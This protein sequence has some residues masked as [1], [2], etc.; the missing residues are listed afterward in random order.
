MSVTSDPSGMY[1]RI[2]TRPKGTPDSLSLGQR[3]TTYHRETFR[4]VTR[5]ATAQH[6]RVHTSI[7]IQKV[8]RIHAET[9]YSKLV[10]PMS[11]SIA[12]SPMSSSDILPR[13]SPQIGNKPEV[14]VHSAGTG[15]TAVNVVTLRQAWKREKPT[16]AMCVRNV[17]VQCVCNSH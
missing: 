7:S 17:D 3:Q 5:I 13:D 8:S 4:S 16:S 10:Q 15:E 14:A 6:K 11:P 12:G 2:N 1:E 9:L